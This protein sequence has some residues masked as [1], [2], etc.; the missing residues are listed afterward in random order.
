MKENRLD[1]KQKVKHGS[2]M[3]GSQF[4]YMLGCEQVSCVLM[5]CR[6]G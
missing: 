4:D 5:A 3:R 1:A 6:K 2:F